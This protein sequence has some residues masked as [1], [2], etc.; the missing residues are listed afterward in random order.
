MK[1]QNLVNPE[2]ELEIKENAVTFKEVQTEKGA[3]REVIVHG[4][5][6]NVF[7][8]SPDKKIKTD[9]NKWE[10]R[11][12]PFLNQENDKINKNCDGV[13]IHYDEKYL[14]IVFCELKSRN[15]EPNQYE[16]QLINTKL[17]VDYLIVLFNQ[18]FQNK[19]ELE[20]RSIKYVLFYI[21]KQRPL[22]IEKSMREQVEIHPV[23][24]PET[25]RMYHYSENI[26]KYP[27]FKPLYNHVEWKDF[28]FHR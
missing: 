20:V 9:A 14:D 12:N 6:D 16:T 22:K 7:V 27:C 4:L 11:Q 21:S 1:L 28:F 3:L 25:E 8:F 26:V 18:F 5:P 13:I 23:P 10:K 19:S 2:L 15:P 17:L 24:V